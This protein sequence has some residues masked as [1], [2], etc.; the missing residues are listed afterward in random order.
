[1]PKLT[2]DVSTLEPKE[3]Q[4]RKQLQGIFLT[5]LKKI[6]GRTKGAYKGWG[7]HFV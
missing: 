5:Q 3:L 4:R 6:P 2:I 1:M 7:W